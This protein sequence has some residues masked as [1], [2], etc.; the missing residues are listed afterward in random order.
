MLVGSKII[1][2]LLA[3]HS[4]GFLG[5]GGYVWTMRILGVVLLFMALFHQGGNRIYMA[6]MLS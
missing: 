5:A 3:H 1:V 2:A 4:R 6:G